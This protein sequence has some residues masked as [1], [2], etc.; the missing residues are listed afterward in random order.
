MTVGITTGGSF[1]FYQQIQQFGSGTFFAR[2][3][4]FW[5]NSMSTKADYLDALEVAILTKHKC[6]PTHRETVFVQEK[7][8][9]GEMVWEG[10]VEVFDVTGHKEAQK[11]YAWWHTDGHG[12][13]I[14]TVLGNQ[15][16]SS[17]QRAIQAAIFVDVQPPAPKFANR[18]IS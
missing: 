1:S 11:C 16:V 8:T 14:F 3:I 17:A 15:V 6:T 5:A 10:Q 18:F 4:E 13:K 12:T 9:D 7:T 2:V